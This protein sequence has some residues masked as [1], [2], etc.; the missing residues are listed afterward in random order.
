MKYLFLYTEPADYTI[1]CMNRH[2][3][4]NPQDEIHL[5]HYPLNPEAP[6]QFDQTK[7][8]RLYNK[9]DLGFEG[10][11]EL[12]EKL[13]PNAIVCS[14]WGDK[15]YVKLVRLY[16]N[17]FTFVLCFDNIWY[18]T[19]KQR[20]LLPI[21]RYFIQPLFRYCWVPGPRQEKFAQK[22]GFSKNQIRLGFYAT[23]T[24]WFA[25]I[26]SAA[27]PKK[28]A[29]GKKRFVCMARYIPEKSYDLL[30]NSYIALYEAGHQDWELWCV[31]TG[32][33]F[34]KRV[35]HPG[36]KHLGFVQP[37]EIA[38]VI[39]ST[40]VL[41]LASSFEPWGMV[42]QEFAAAGFPLIL[43]NVVGCAPSLLIDGVNGF[44]FHANNSEDLKRAM[45]KMMET[46]DD[47]LVEMGK[48]SMVMAKQN[49]ATN[50]SGIL[51]ELATV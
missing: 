25:K 10:L 7:G 30:W 27:I 19:L 5:V 17:S 42:V 26:A 13:Q 46:T 34:D 20:F 3:Q 9:L 40:D 24:E 32:R 47:E 16:K 2:L 41:V 49:D 28:N 29:K 33:D 15:V 21:A 35:E 6:F 51:S 48:N 36:I 4:L 43:S 44:A 39:E 8:I 12:I 18:A 11:F 45:L 38:A 22:M 50:W 23:D 37:A 14:G 1:K 31:G